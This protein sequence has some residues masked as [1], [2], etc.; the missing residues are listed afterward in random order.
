[1]KNN[2]AMLLLFLLSLKAI[3]SPQSP[4]L[5]IYKNDT[6]PTYNLLIE[7]YLREKFN[8]DELAKFSFKGELIPLSCWRGYQGVYEVID[9]KLY[10]SGMIDCGGLRNK[11]DL[12][13]NESLARMRK[14]INIMIKMSTSFV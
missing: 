13:S 11:Q 2:V 12:F 3:A 5:I 9:N 14:L 8:D 7:R 4:D 6:I 10:L 1:M